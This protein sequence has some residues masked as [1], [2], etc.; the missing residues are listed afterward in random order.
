MTGLLQKLAAA[1]L[2]GTSLVA[3]AQAAETCDAAYAGK[4][5]EIIV[6]APAG[7]G[8]DVVARVLAASL[9]G[10]LGNARIDVK[11][12]PG[13][14]NVTA[15]TYLATPEENKIKL[16]YY[17]VSDLL[18]DAGDLKDADFIP[19]GGVIDE[20]LLLIGRSDVTVDTLPKATTYSTVKVDERSVMNVHVPLMLLGLEPVPVFGMTGISEILA[21]IARSELDVS[22]IALTSA[23]RQ[24]KSFEGLHLF[25]SLTDT[26][27]ADFPDVPA[28]GD[29]IRARGTTG[30]ASLAADVPLLTRSIRAVHV[31]KDMVKK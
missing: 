11:N 15:A 18:E 19:V 6:P 3:G 30:D 22:A 7:G 31:Y 24:L 14:R 10:Q 5:V 21:S 12:L 23:K 28:F 8:Y 4:S 25:L 16:G 2:F 9:Q 20:P 17:N 27:V 29:L 26:P 1:A 13:A